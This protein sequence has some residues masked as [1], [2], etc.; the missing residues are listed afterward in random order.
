MENKLE[1]SSINLW[2]DHKALLG[3]ILHLC[4]FLIIQLSFFAIGDYNAWHIFKLN[5][6]GENAAAFLK[7]VEDYIHFH[8]SYQFNV[9]TAVLLVALC[10]HAGSTLINVLKKK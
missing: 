7:Q 8:E 3:L 2:K 10:L 1:V 6:G 4:I 5:A 9:I